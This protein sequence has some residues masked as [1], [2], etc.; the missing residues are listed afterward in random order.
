M[1]ALMAG[2]PGRCHA[3]LCRD[4]S[5]ALAKLCPWQ[6]LA[7]HLAP[8]IPLTLPEREAAAPTSRRKPRASRAGHHAGGATAGAP[9][10]ADQLVMPSLLSSWFPA[11]ICNL[12]L[13]GN[14]FPLRASSKWGAHS[15]QFCPMHQRETG[16]LLFLCISLC[17]HHG[18]F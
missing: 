1:A 13:P 6:V 8:M 9:H 15:D 16:G 12:T 18:A 2:W 10:L 11:S 7:L 14:L 5:G 4:D 17:H 3:D